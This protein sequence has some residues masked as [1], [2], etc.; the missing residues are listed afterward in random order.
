MGIDWGN[1]LS[2]AG[3][4]AGAGASIGGPLG[5]AVGGGVGLLTG[6]FGGADAPPEYKNYSDPVTSAAIQRLLS[7]KLGQQQANRAATQLRQQANTQMQQFKENPNFQGNAS[8]LAALNN[9]LQRQA[10]SGTVDAQLK[11][12]EIDQNAILQAA[13][14]QQQQQQFGLR[15]NEFDLGRYQQGLQ[16]S[17]LESLFGQGVSAAVGSALGKQAGKSPGGDYNPNDFI[18]P[19]QTNFPTRN[20]GGGG[21]DLGG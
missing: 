10:E 1:A 16:P 9:R 2:M 5:A 15:R 12:A 14:L 13:N 4:G 7:Q 20:I 18:N 6:L 17:Y 8:V 21:I 11:G 3:T 19:S